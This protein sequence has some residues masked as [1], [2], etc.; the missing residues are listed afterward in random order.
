MSE[1][2]IEIPNKKDLQANLFDLC[3]YIFLSILSLKYDFRYLDTL[4][5][6]KCSS[7]TYILCKILDRNNLLVGIDI[8]LSL[9]KY[10]D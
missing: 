2:K 9:L 1:S 4:E 3:C 6:S 8:E 5:H 7:T 10:L